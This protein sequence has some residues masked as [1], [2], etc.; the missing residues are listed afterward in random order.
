MG[1][2]FVDYQSVKFYWNTAELALKAATELD[3]SRRTRTGTLEAA[4]ESLL[5]CLQD[6][7]DASSDRGSLSEQQAAFDLYRD[8]IVR[9]GLDPNL[10]TVA[11]LV[12]AIGSFCTK[13]QTQLKGRS[14]IELHAM[15]RTSLD[16]HQFCLSR[17][18]EAHVQEGLRTA[19]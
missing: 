3:R 7:V 8:A 11:D 12:E 14:D 4:V 18:M 5:K 2:H 17:S 16:I 6:A 19:A 13:W 1:V 9:P 15:M 10:R